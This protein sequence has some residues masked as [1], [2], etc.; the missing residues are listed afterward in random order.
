MLQNVTQSD[1]TL[2]H[3]PFPLFLYDLAGTTE[4]L[5]PAAVLPEQFHGRTSKTSVVRG[6]VALMRAVLFDAVE[7]FHKQAS[8]PSQNAQRLAREAER[9]LFADDDQKRRARTALSLERDRNFLQRRSVMT[10]KVWES[11]F[12]NLHIRTR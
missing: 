3:R 5:P 10:T 6:E 2:P 7:C 12:L 4:F 11:P 8:E 9:R 1:K